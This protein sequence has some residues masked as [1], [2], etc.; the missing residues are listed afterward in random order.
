MGKRNYE[1]LKIMFALCL[2]NCASQMTFSNIA[3]LLPT[4]FKKT[5]PDVG[6]FW[7]GLLL[8]AYPLTYAI[9]VPL[10]GSKLAKIG[11]KNTVT[12]GVFLM[13]AASILLGLAGYCGNLFSFLTLSFIAR[14]SQGVG[15][16]LVCVGVPSIVLIEYPK[17]CAFYLGV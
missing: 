17:Q 3:V 9:T 12:G 10:L 8:A 15:D 13:G 4:Y 14:L 1:N 5:Y 2:I 11:R 6:T 16:G 7:V